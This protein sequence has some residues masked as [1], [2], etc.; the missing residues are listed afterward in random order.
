[1]KYLHPHYFHCLSKTISVSIWT[2]INKVYARWWQVNLGRGNHFQGKVYFRKELQSQI[3]IGNNCLFYSNY[4]SNN[5][6]VRG[7]CMISTIKRGASVYIGS[8]C[9]FSG[10]VIAAAKSITIGN[11]VKCGANCV[12][13]DSDWH[14]EDYR[15]RKDLPVC[16]EDNVWLG[17]GVIVLKGVH[18]GKNSLIGA[19]SIVTMDIPSN[20]I[21]AGNPC[22]IIRTI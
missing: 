19:G 4:S 17:Y 16:I 6:G 13:T 21:A 18:I 9:G 10:T 2:L 1:M 12:I 20:V 3:S 7:P 11:H 8:E 22:R 15:S 5:I 14:P